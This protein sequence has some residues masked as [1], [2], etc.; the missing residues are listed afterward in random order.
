MTLPFIVEILRPFHH[1]CYTEISEGDG[2]RLRKNTDL[3]LAK[4]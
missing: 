2:D 3:D 1:R 4:V